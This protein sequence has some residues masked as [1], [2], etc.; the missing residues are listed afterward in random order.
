MNQDYSV[1]QLLGQ[2][3]V[4]LL[5]NRSSTRLSYVF[6]SVRSVCVLVLVNLGVSYCQAS[7]SGRCAAH[8]I[9]IKVISV[10]VPFKG[11]NV[12]YSSLYDG[13]SAVFLGVGFIPVY[14]LL[15]STSIML[16]CI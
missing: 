15:G 1:L 11:Y 3:S 12:R 6:R 4:H 16:K 8:T 2:P 9:F 13:M 14:V 5:H 7:I 10:S